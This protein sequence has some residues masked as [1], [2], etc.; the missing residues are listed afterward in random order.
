MDLIKEDLEPSNGNA[1][2]LDPINI[3]I[4][5]KTMFFNNIG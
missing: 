4:P 3:P 5:L 1:A 2:T